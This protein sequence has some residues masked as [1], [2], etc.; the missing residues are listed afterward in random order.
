MKDL[1][2]LKQLH[3]VADAAYLRKSQK[4]QELVTEEARLRADLAK[5][6][7]GLQQARI[8]DTDFDLN[9]LGGDALWRG[10]VGQR[11]SD[12]NLKLARVLALK[13]QQISVIRKAFGK[14]QI[15][16]TMVKEHQA[17]FHKE[18]Q[19][20]TLERAIDQSIFAGLSNPGARSQ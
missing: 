9:A 19:K 10:W 14:R 17:K 6:D 8:T 11:K 7:E 1:D 4:F 13:E 12:I 3:A 20:N 15:T 2:N 5:L 18:Q 16:E